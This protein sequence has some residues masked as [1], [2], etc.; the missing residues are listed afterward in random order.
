MSGSLNK[1]MLIGNLGRDPEVRTMQDGKK[2]ANLN[3]ACSE[4][5]RDKS[6]GERKERTEWA[7]VVIFGALAEIAEKYTKK[8]SKIYISGSMQT[9]NWTDKDG[10][11]KYTTEVVVQGF[12][13]ELVLLDGK[14]AGNAPDDSS[15]FE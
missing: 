1:V 12:G 14:P 9:R 11:E 13:G 2:V 7:R 3:L 10:A 4:S 15:G 8:G 6:T 5:W